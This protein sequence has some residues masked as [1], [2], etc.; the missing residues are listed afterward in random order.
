MK[1]KTLRIVALTLGLFAVLILGL[2]GWM[3]YENF[4]PAQRATDFTNLTYPGENGVTLNAY[5]AQPEGEGPFPG[6]L[7]I[8]EFFGI[9]EDI[10]KKADLLAEQGY[11]VLAI[12]AYRGKTTASIPRAIFLVISTP[13]KQIAADVDA[14]YDYLASLPQVAGQQVGAV[15]F[16]FGGTQVM[17]MGTCN[18]SLAAAA[19]FYGSGPITDPGDL[20]MMG[21]SGPV[22][23]IYGAEDASIPLEE[24][25]GFRK[26]LEERGIE[27]TITVYP[28]VGHAFVH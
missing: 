13:Q 14:G 25:E 12:D 9:N 22:L 5:L 28:G 23:G 10:I 4:F 26:A 6:V 24:V 11:V 21:I 19:I 7:M 8:H 18:A 15:G 2:L 17:N 3:A 20:G 27:H 1:K 16:C